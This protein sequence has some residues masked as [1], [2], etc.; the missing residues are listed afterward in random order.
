MKVVYV[1]NLDKGLD[2]TRETRKEDKNGLSII[3][4]SLASLLYLFLISL[5][6]SLYLVRQSSISLH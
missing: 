1:L 2:L 5:L 3:I 4:Y 6:P